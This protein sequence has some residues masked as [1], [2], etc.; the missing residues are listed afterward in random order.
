[1]RRKEIYSKN[2]NEKKPAS[3]SFVF[4]SFSFP[5]VFILVMLIFSNWN[6][7][8]I[9][10]RQRS[11]SSDKN[12]YVVSRQFSPAK[13]F[14]FALYIIVL[15]TLHSLQKWVYFARLLIGLQS[16]PQGIQKSCVTIRYAKFIQKFFILTLHLTEILGKNFFKVHSISESTSSSAMMM[17]QFR[18]ERQ[19]IPYSPFEC[20]EQQTDRHD[21][22]LSR[23]DFQFCFYSCSCYCS[24]IN[25]VSLIIWNYISMMTY[26]D[27]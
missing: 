27:L 17:T 10:D 13:S 16:M 26:I 3:S 18:D 4:S 23:Y 6:S 25:Y 14:V 22:R 2:N 20:G 1:M 8:E 5:P 7:R 21:W 11:S 12:F 19:M 15:Y 24:V 9:C